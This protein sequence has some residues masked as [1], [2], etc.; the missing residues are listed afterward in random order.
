MCSILNS[1][2]PPL[3]TYNN[4]KNCIL[5]QTGL[6]LVHEEYKSV[7][8]PFPNQY[9]MKKLD[10]ALENCFGIGKLTHTFD[11]DGLTTNTFLIYAPNGTMKSSFAKTFS[12]LSKND[13]K[14]L[15]C[16]RIHS[17]RI[18]VFDV[19]CDGKPIT[20]ES[21]L[22]ID[23][24][25]SDFDASD[26]ISS[27]IAS[28]DLKEKYDKIYQGL[29]EK[30]DNFIT[31]LKGVSKSSDC[32]EELFNTFK[33][34]DKDTIF[35]ILTRTA[36]SL[37]EKPVN[38]SFKYNTIFDKKGNVQKFLQ[39]NEK[40][41]NQYI[42]KYKEVLASSTFF[43]SSA[44][45]FGTY[46]ANEIIKSI[47]GDSYFHA[48]HTFTLEGGKVITS[49]KELRDIVRSELDRIIND[50]ELKKA[51]DTVD[52]AITNNQELR[53]FQ[54]VVN[55]D[56]S[57]LIELKSY[58]D[59][60]KKV[61][62]DY[63]S[64]MNVDVDELL[65][66]YISQK[67]TLETILEEARKEVSLW[68]EIIEKFNSRFYVPFMVSL[69]NQEDIILKEETATLEFTY[70]D[71]IEA[72]KKQDRDSLINILSKGEQRAYHILQF[73]F[74]IESRK[75]LNIDTLL[76]LD[77]IADSFDYK[78]KFA[79]IEYIK[80]LHQSNKFKIIIL[81]H[82]FDFYRTIGSRLYLNRKA[83]YMVVKGATREITLATGQYINDIFP[84]FLTKMSNKEFF[85]SL[86][87][88][89]RN[90]IEY[91]EGDTCQEYSTLTSC[92]HIKSDTGN[93]DADAILNLYNLKV[94]RTL[95]KTITFGSTNIKDLIYQTADA[96]GSLA[97]PDEVALEN[98][99][100]LSI[101]IRLKAEEYILT[102]LP[103]S[104][105]V[106]GIRSKQ[107]RVLYDEFVKISTN[108][109]AVKVLDRVNLMTPENIHINAFMFEPLID[110]SVLHLASLYK[111][112][113][114]LV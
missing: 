21:I 87:P 20:A 76:I 114:L 41:L 50:T 67:S 96:I 74:E 61:W 12:L 35:E 79:I 69:G 16:D 60:K 106:L 99:I 14:Q 100:V 23:A 64:Q 92:L 102:K 110:M 108:M 48:G 109:D 39:K 54:K 2:S 72:P 90:I 85:I 30:K 1:D 113:K 45:S 47:E 18:S 37:L 59:F 88:F 27:F 32:E 71:K 56:N 93:I 57:L 9:E 26:K 10:I 77:D 98:K 80:D 46:Q 22:V 25:N 81:T 75:A 104:Y 84:Y 83:I 44:N 42:T 13:S 5:N 65:K 49:S 70:D 95:G 53:L 97:N 36:P 55:D 89:V 68:K 94:P 28:K 66:F 111:D 86:L 38:Y 24:E 29:E 103:S 51:F 91:S 112:I 4:Y 78:N 34:S 8:I 105:N 40:A 62:I 17:H 107:T 101:A 31:K 11:F 58:D 15:P 3:V 52:K 6:H 73:L 82:N 63:L 43:K 7:V 19:L 33:I